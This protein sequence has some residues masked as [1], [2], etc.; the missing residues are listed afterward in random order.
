MCVGLPARVMKMKDGRAVVDASGAQREISAEL[1]ADLEP[2]DYV[3][4]H[5][6]TAI[7]KIGGDDEAEADA[8]LSEILSQ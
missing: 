8:L 5:A 6:G 1:L 2:G 7:A 4:I 3:M